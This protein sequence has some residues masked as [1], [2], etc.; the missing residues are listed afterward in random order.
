MRGTPF[1]AGGGLTRAGSAATVGGVSARAVC[2]KSPDRTTAA[3]MLSLMFVLL[4][5]PPVD[6]DA[7]LEEPRAEDRRRPPPERAER[8][9]QPRYRGGVE[10]V[11]HVELPL[12]ARLA[13][14]EDLREAQI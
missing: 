9:A 13:E 7:E 3:A 14:A 8:A 1:P 10:R 2:A 6:L 11:V 4:V 5:L 12:Q